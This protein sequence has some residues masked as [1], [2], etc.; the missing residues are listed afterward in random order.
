MPLN[1]PQTASEADP[2]ILGSRL[3][4]TMT[5][6]C[7]VQCSIFPLTCASCGSPSQ[8]QPHH[9][10]W[11]LESGCHPWVLSSP[12]PS[13]TSNQSPIPAD[14]V[15]MTHPSRL[16]LLAGV[17]QSFPHSAKSTELCVTSLP[18]TPPA[19][20]FLSSCFSNTKLLLFYLLPPAC[21]RAVPSSCISFLGLPSSPS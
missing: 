4:S 9:Q 3:V 13:W 10:P 19:S 16:H 11:R 20:S 6:T 12:Q 7:T 5:Q 1:W 21:A 8:R 18:L 2:L 17:S 14:F 15:S